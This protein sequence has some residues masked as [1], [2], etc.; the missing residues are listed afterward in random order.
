[1]WGPAAFSLVAGF[2]GSH[3]VFPGLASTLD[4]GDDVI[5]R[6][7]RALELPAAVLAAILIPGENIG[8]GESND[9]FSLSEG[10]IA[11]KSKDRRHLHTKADRPNLEISF[12][13]HFYFSLKQQL[14]GT[15]P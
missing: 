14:E 7:L 9:L 5:Q 1:L 3:Y 12:F 2:A 6:E 11:E 10:N 8:S 4:N 15:L 13:D